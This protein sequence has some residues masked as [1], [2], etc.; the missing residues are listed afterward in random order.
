MSGTRDEQGV[1]VAIRGQ[2]FVH[3][4]R[5]RTTD[6]VRPF[7]QALATARCCAWTADVAPDTVDL[8]LRAV[9]V[10]DAPEARGPSPVLAIRAALL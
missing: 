3:Y 2:A 6:A 7:Q 4:S 1:A 10:S 9:H 8:D 5:G